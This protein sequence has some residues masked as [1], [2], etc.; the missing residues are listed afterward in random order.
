MYSA[1]LMVALSGGSATPAHLFSNCCG[2]CSGCYS[3]SCAC[4]GSH[5]YSCGHSFSLFSHGCCGGGCH[6]C[7]SSCHG[8]LFSHGCCGGGCHGC[9]SS[10]HGGLFSH[11]CCGG[12]CHGCFSSCHGCNGCHGFS[13][14]S[15]FHHNHG[16]CGGCNGCNGCCGGTVVQPAP[17]PPPPPPPAKPGD[18][19]ADA[20]LE[21]RARLTVEV[22]AEAKLFVD[23]FETKASGTTVRSF[24]TPELEAG[25]D[26][27]YILKIETVRDGK[28]VAETQQVTVRAGQETRASFT[29][30]K[31]ATASAN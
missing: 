15:C 27:Y 2:G 19:K 21:N 30:A 9:F 10:C 3:S 26:Y 25:Q 13:L 22:P 24:T 8:S 28:T 12:G 4:W 20:E 17:A 11:G 18:K 5:A 7:F 23:G 14:F 6:G 29:E 16:C 1:L 31:L